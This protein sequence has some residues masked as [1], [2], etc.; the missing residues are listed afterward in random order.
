MAGP[1]RVLQAMAGPNRG[2][3]EA[4]FVRLVRALRD[5]D[6]RQHVVVKQGAY[7]GGALRALGIEPEELEFGGM[8]DLTTQGRLRRSIAR[9]QPNIVLSW[10]NRATRFCSRSRSNDEFVHV[11]RLGGYYDLKYYRGCDHLVA[12]TRNIADYV[13]GA[14][15]SPEV[16]HYLPNFVDAAPAPALVR[17]TLDTPDDVPLLLSLGRL[18]RNKG[19]DVLLEALERLPEVYLWLA[20]SGSLAADLDAQSRALGIAERVRFLGWREDVASLYAAADL[21]V[22]PSRIEPLGNVVIEAWAHSRPVV[23]AAAAGPESLI[24]HERSGLLVAIDDAD[25]LAEAI[26]RVMNL[27]GLRDELVRGGHEAYLRDY[28]ERAA[29]LRYREF[30]ESVTA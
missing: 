26:R 11:G 5:A 9:F 19:F 4:F 1:L 18:H 15:W 3:A 27:P 20:G 28:T 13:V 17:S 12:N 16:V 8:L 6:V 25:A 7:A 22:C 2:G 10:M 23:A 29:V 24:K 21:Y 14:G 30:F